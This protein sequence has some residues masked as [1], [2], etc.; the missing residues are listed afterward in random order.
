MWAVVYHRRALESYEF[1]YRRNI[2]NICSF[3]PIKKI[4]LISAK[5]RDFHLEDPSTD[6]KL[7]VNTLIKKWSQQ[8]WRNEGLN[9]G[10][11]QS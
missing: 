11:C 7:S 1:E 9:I 2:F 8:L 6:K 4:L 5:N 3:R 10:I